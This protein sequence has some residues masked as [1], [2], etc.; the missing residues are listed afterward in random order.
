M[1]TVSVCID[2]TE[3]FTNAHIS[4]NHT[5]DVWFK[6]QYIYAEHIPEF[7][8]DTNRSTCFVTEEISENPFLTI[9]EIVSNHD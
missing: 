3:T 5:D 4:W 8:D 6:K 7:T 1:Y 9:S 2:N